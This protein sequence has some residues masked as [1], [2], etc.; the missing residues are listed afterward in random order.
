MVKKS[1]WLATLVALAYG[2]GARA[3]FYVHSANVQTGG[4]AVASDINRISGPASGGNQYV[5]N[6]STNTPFLGGNIR[7]VGVSG[8]ATFQ[9]RGDG[10][11]N[12]MF[13]GSPLAAVF[14]L[15]GVSSPGGA[16]FTATGGRVG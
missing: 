10:P 8:L 13:N 5:N 4:G 9:R 15:S 12:A 16:T 3:D 6:I 14:A 2:A 7:V 11:L 1:A